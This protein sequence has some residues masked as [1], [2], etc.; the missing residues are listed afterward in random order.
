MC[1]VEDRSRDVA[2]VASV[3]QIQCFCVTRTPNVEN[4]I[5]TKKKTRS[6]VIVQADKV[7]IHFHVKCKGY[8]IG[9]M[10][11]WQHAADV[12]EARQ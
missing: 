3:S 10:F 1:V 12:S 11:M 9:F 6:T 2:S 7:T 8:V 4:L 5:S